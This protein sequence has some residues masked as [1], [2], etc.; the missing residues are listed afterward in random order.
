MIQPF[1]PIKIHPTSKY[2]VASFHIDLPYSHTELVEE[3]EKE[4]WIP[5]GEI[6]EVG[7]NPWPGTRY[8][9]LWPDQGNKKLTELWNYCCSDKLK[10][11]FID[12]M[13]QYIRNISVDWDWRPENMFKSCHLHGEFTKDMPGFVNDIH[14]DYRKLVAT[15]MIYLT[16]KD[17]PDLSTY[18]CDDLQRTNQFRINTNFGD[19]WWHANGNDTWHEGWNKTDQVRYS[20]L[21]ALTVNTE[22]LDRYTKDPIRNTERQL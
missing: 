22:F 3:L 5:H 16:D 15:G 18:F 7:N 20:I 13:Y 12:W 14:T 1:Y 10:Q 11:T 17:N 4:N 2:R 19:G 6:G 8:K 21:L 9:V